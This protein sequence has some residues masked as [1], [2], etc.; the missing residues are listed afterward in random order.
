MA[1]PHEST[2]SACGTPLCPHIAC[3][4]LVCS[5]GN[6]FL[7]FHFLSLYTCENR[8][9]HP[10]APQVWDDGPIAVFRCRE[11]LRQSCLRGRTIPQLFLGPPGP[12]SLVLSWH[13]SA[14]PLPSD[15]N[16]VSTQP[17]FSNAAAVLHGINDLRFEE[18][19]PLPAMVAPGAVRVGIKAVGIC[20]SDVHYLQK[21]R[22][23]EHTGGCSCAT[24]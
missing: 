16:Q 23:C 20:R 9:H 22:S 5:L 19:P 4:I 6:S 7:L 17:A 3:S 1:S 18:A 2:A 12:D 21:V 10:S 13:R 15:N 24:C 8:A 14:L 11:H